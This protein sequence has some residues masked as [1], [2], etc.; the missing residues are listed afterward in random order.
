MPSH[1]P[2]EFVAALFMSRLRWSLLAGNA[3]PTLKPGTTDSA[4]TLLDAKFNCRAQQSEC[5]L[6]RRMRDEA[7]EHGKM[8]TKFDR[9]SIAGSTRW[10]NIV[11][12]QFVRNRQTE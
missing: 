3:T 11:C 8:R 12:T 7:P 9:L 6:E 2:E 1:R 4:M 5:R 10:A